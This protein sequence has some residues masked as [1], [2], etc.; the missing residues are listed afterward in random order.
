MNIAFFDLDYTLV[1][2][3]TSTL[4]IK[5]LLRRRMISLR[6][7]FYITWVTAQYKLNVM[8]FPKTTVHLSRNLRGGN[9][10]AT[11][12]LCEQFVKDD[13]L[14][15]ITP[16]GLARLREHQAKG[17]YVLLLSASTQF[18]VQPVADHLNIPCRFTELE[19][20]NDGTFTGGIVGPAAY[21]E[22]K[23][24]WGERIAKEQ[25]VPL[26]DCWF[27]TDSYSDS[28]LMDIVGHPIAINPDRKLNAYA[29]K[30]GWPVEYFY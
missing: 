7:F 3:S 12:K 1:S 22:G 28:P 13:V 15:H 4:Y 29:Q 16:K 26:D 19:I 9:A 18:V 27:Y 24:Y 20:G 5:Y 8:D 2:K 10:A 17:D 21:A 6:E 14:P 25:G 30:K 11:Q 23:R